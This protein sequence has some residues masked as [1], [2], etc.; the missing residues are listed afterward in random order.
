MSERHT[1]HDGD[2]TRD[3]GGDAEDYRGEHFGLTPEEERRGTPL[4]QE[5]GGDEPQIAGDQ[6]NP[7]PD[8]PVPGEPN[9]P[10]PAQPIPDPNMPDPMRPYPEPGDPTRPYPD[11]NQ[12]DPMRPYP[13]PGDP[14]PGRPLP[15]GPVTPHPQ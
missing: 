9:R 8:R 12:P 5:I 10:D 7:V 6:D 13:E 1:A 11:P 3:G 15:G 2:R 4:Q 14:E